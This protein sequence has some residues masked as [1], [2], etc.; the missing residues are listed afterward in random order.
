ML[1]LITITGYVGIIIYMLLYN[2]YATNNDNNYDND[3]DNNDN[4]NNSD[5]IMI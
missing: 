2:D 4:N 5:N 3:N 1:L